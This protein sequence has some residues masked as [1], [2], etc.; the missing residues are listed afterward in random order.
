MENFLTNE[1]CD[2]IISAAKNSGLSESTTV[3][4]NRHRLPVEKIMELFGKVDVNSD[5]ILDTYEVYEI[6]FCSIG[7][8]EKV[9][10]DVDCSKI[11]NLIGYSPCRIRQLIV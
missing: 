11:R 8:K 9:Y 10:P 6:M 2:L 1:E 7:C 4:A 5:G 3:R